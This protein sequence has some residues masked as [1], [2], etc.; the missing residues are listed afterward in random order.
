MKS[1]QQNL[2]FSNLSLNE[3][4]AAIIIIL[5]GDWC[6]RLALRTPSGACHKRR[7]SGI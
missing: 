6:L 1:I 2:K 7:R 3:E 4:I 5:Y